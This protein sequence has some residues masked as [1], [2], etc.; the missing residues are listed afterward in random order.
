MYLET[1]VKQFKKDL[2]LA[3]KQKKP[4]YILE[5]IIDTLKMGL[6]LDPKYKDHYLSNNYRGCKECHLTPDWLLIYKI[7]KEENLLYLLRLGSHS[8]LFE[9]VDIIELNNILNEYLSN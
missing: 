1:P 9:T 5:E 2:K 4:L 8:E 3:Q 6:E 7:V